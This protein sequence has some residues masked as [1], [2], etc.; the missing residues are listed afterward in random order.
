MQYYCVKMALAPHVVDYLNRIG[1]SIVPEGINGQLYLRLD[2]PEGTREEQANMT[3][4]N[5]VFRVVLPSEGV[6]YVTRL[7][8]PALPD[9]HKQHILHVFQY[10]MKHYEMQQM[11]GGGSA[12]PKG[13]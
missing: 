4:Y 6:F 13:E 3:Q 8:R 11:E 10:D 1:A 5:D 7:P 12:N 9:G 2:C